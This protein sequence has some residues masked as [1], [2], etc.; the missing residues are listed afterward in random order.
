VSVENLR[1]ERE[2]AERL[3]VCLRTLRS[4]RARRYGPEPT[5][6]GRFIYYTPEAEQRFLT[7]AEQAFETSPRPRRQR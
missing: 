7:K 3:G 4:W 1:S 2:E 6:I 5:I